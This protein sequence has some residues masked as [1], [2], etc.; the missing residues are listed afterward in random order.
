MV[1]ANHRPAGVTLS[2][3]ASLPPGLIKDGPLYRA[4]RTAPETH[5]TVPGN[6]EDAVLCGDVDRFNA[7]KNKFQILIQSE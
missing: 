1:D 4:I 6:F 3:A 7:D 2:L 5:T